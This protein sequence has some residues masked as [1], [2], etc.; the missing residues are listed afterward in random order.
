MRRWASLLGAIAL[1]SSACG[2]ARSFATVSL[3]DGARGGG[4]SVH[5]LALDWVGKPHPWQMPPPGSACV[6]YQVVAV[7]IDG[8]RHELRPDQFEA[9]GR[10][11]ARAVGQCDAPQF[12]PTWV[13]PQP[14]VVPVTIV[15]PADIPLPD[16]RWR[17]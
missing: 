5:V 14:V 7:S 4:V 3:A 12:E 17:P 13:G 16:L 8:R 15:V 10:S 11:P 6:D 1:L 9:A 2:P